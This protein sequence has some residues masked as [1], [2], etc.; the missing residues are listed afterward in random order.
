MSDTVHLVWRNEHSHDET[1]IVY[2]NGEPLGTAIARHERDTNF[3]EIAFAPDGDRGAA[4]IAGDD[5]HD[6]LW[7]AYQVIG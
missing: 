4:W 3:L 2:V 1:L 7:D 5:A 6:L